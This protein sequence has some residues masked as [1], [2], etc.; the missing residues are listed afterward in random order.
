VGWPGLDLDP[1]QIVTFMTAA[2]AAV[3]TAS[4]KWLHGCQQHEHLVAE[5]RTIPVAKQ[6]KIRAKMKP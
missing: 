2:T 6:K 4:W 3:L 1:T 5:G